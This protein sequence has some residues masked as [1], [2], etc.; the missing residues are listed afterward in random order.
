MDRPSSPLSDLV[1][2]TPLQSSP[3][4]ELSTFSNTTSTS[5]AYAKSVH[6]LFDKTGIC[7]QMPIVEGMPVQKTKYW[8]LIIV[9][10]TRTRLLAVDQAKIN[11]ISQRGFRVLITTFTQGKVSRIIRFRSCFP[12]IHL[13]NQ[14]WFQSS[15]LAVHLM[16]IRSF[17]R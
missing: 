9:G 15:Y 14:S 13:L 12:A 6:H 10:S 16:Y 1:G 4:N 3:P 17:L 5:R 8:Q 2:S 7:S 11:K